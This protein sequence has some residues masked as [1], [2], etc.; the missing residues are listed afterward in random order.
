MT[1]R[2]K[3]DVALS[4]AGEDRA[5]VE[6]VADGLRSRGVS[7]FYDRFETAKLWGKD[8]YEHLTSI[9]K[10]K[11]SYTVL[12]ISKHY[13]EK[14]WARVERRAALARAFQEN[15]EY[16]LPARFD[17][18]E[19]EGLLGTVG[20][21]DLRQVSPLEICILICE[22]VGR[23]PFDM[24]A[25]LMPSPNCCSQTGIARFDH[26]SHNGCFRIGEGIAL[27]ETKWSRAGGDCVHCYNDM[28]SVRGVAIAPKGALLSDI[29]AASELDFTSR[30]RTPER[31][32]FVV[33]QNS[34]GLYAALE[35]VN[36]KDDKF[37]DVQ[38]ELTFKYWILN[39]GSEDFSKIQVA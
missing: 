23:K 19:I 10:D 9:Y 4:F 25:D 18:T 15:R 6:M 20:Y 30:T 35:I 29:K 38:N 5:Y 7:V 3:Y 33:L 22:K 21:I 27:F 32:R 24:K 34:N 31:N 14:L 11:A 16:I 2:K 39:D 36:V 37:G 8:L 1:D 17:D 26:S 12:F 13:A 28:P